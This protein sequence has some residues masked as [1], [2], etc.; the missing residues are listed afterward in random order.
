MSY[1]KIIKYNQFKIDY[2]FNKII[3]LNTQNGVPFIIGNIDLNNITICMSGNI[4]SLKKAN[5]DVSYNVYSQ[6]STIE[7]SKAKT[8]IYVDTSSNNIEDSKIIY[9]NGGKPDYI[10]TAL[11]NKSGGGNN[12][13]GYNY[14]SRFDISLNQFVKNDGNKFDYSLNNLQPLF[15]DNKYVIYNDIE[16]KRITMSNNYNLAVRNMFIYENYTSQLQRNN[17]SAII[18]ND[19]IYLSYTDTNGLHIKKVVFTNNTSKPFIT[20]TIQTIQNILINNLKILF[21]DELITFFLGRT[22]TPTVDIYMLHKNTFYNITNVSSLNISSLNIPDSIINNNSTPI[23]DCVI[24]RNTE[25][26]KIN[27]L[28]LIILSNV[29][30]ILR[31]F[32]YVALKNSIYNGNLNKFVVLQQTLADKKSLVKKNII[33]PFILYDNIEN[34]LI[35]YNDPLKI[36]IL[37]INILENNN[38]IDLYLSDLITSGSFSNGTGTGTKAYYITTNSSDNGKKIIYKTQINTSENSSNTVL[39]LPNGGGDNNL[40]MSMQV[41]SGDTDGFYPLITTELDSNQNGNKSIY[42]DPIKNRFIQYLQKRNFIFNNIFVTN[43]INNDYMFMYWLKDYENVIFICEKY[44]ESGQSYYK[45]F[46]ISDFTYIDTNYINGNTNFTNDPSKIFPYDPSNMSLF[47]NKTTNKT[48]ISYIDANSNNLNNKIISQINFGQEYTILKRSISY[49]VINYNHVDNPINNINNNTKNTATLINKINVT[50][51]KNINYYTENLVQDEYIKKLLYCNDLLNIFLT[52]LGRLMYLYSD[53][54]NGSYAKFHTPSDESFTLYEIPY[55]FSDNNGFKIDNIYYAQDATATYNSEMKTIEIALINNLGYS[56]I[57]FND[58]SQPCFLSTTK[59]LTINSN[60]EEEYKE[61]S[62]LLSG[63]YVKTP[64]GKTCKIK[65]CGYT[66]PFTMMDEMDYPRIIPKDYFGDKLPEEQIYASGWH[67]I[68]LPKDKTY[69]LN[70]QRA[71]K[72]SKSMLSIQNELESNIYNKVFLFTFTE[73]KVIKSI[74]EIQELTGKPT[75][76]Y[77]N[78]ELEDP[79]Q[80]YIVSGLPVESLSQ[81]LWS[82]FRFTDNQ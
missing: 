39:L 25:N 74:Q 29:G 20:Q 34:Y 77:Y 58:Q 71:I 65:H 42:N 38:T 8:I 60:G 40:V 78:I 48:Y 14:N 12:R 26:D 82:E 28:T 41:I 63:D 61:I 19:A 21:T 68:Y 53:N 72:L 23:I 66:P 62:K 69:P 6:T 55:S 52:N 37:K 27:C 17:L 76:N 50:S 43:D 3:E 9:I 7:T 57:T 64:T 67:A 75:A 80:G 1:E 49:D 79:T 10:Q 24:Y 13:S 51:N 4:L 18:I 2:S 15:I 73:L 32:D 81:D 11:F 33:N 44:Q 22:T 70:I 5:Y 56:I 54:R 16:M 35:Y 30:V 59:V 46:I 47:Y 31:T 45:V 36:K